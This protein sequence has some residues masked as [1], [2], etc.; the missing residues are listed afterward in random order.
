MTKKQIIVDYFDHAAKNR[1]KGR[2]RY[3]Y[4]YRLVENYLGFYVPEGS[5]VLVVGC[6]TGELLDALKPAEGVGVDISPE[7]IA[8]ARRNFPQY[9][10][11]VGDIEELMLDRTFDVVI[12]SDVIGYLDDIQATFD[13]LRSVC[14]PRT[15]V[16]ITYFSIFWQFPLLLAEKLRLKLR[17]PF[18]A[19]LDPDDIANLLDLAEFDII[20]KNKKILLPVWIPL[21]SW[22][23]NYI[24]ANLPLLRHMCLLEIVSARLRPQCRR[25]EQSVTVLIPTRNEKGNIAAALERLPEFGSRREV[26]FVDGH[27]TDG[28]LEEIRT[29]AARHP[30]LDIRWFEQDGRGKGDAVRKGFGE[31][32]G[33]ILMI[34]DA[35]LTVPPE[36]LP[37]FYDAIVEGK[38]EFIN[39]SRLVYPMEDRA[40][41]FLNV[42]G[43]KFFSIVFTWLLDQRFKDTLCGTKVLTR[44][45][46]LKIAAGRHYFG[47]FDPFGDF[48]L[49]FGAAKLNLK[50]TEVP[51]RYRERIYGS[52]NISR[53][54][55]GWILLKMCVYAYRKIKMI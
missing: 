43:N 27:S 49:I 23:F 12:F 13:R 7:M 22:L 6:G 52:T 44:E 3:R 35:D 47:D 16:M 33:D 50:I 10:F 46:Y 1:S 8:E 55:H 45:N 9:E 2:R 4:F 48:D 39:G 42:L 17:S 28:T 40:M 54:S 29:Q 14:T 19:W 5:S 21:L 31:A 30:E 24:F 53:F 15:R 38:G 32:T 37:K 36:D 41:R 11:L 34:L 20:R 26:V 18:F 25:E 51:I